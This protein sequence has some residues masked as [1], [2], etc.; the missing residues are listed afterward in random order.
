LPIIIWHLGFLGTG[1]YLFVKGPGNGEVIFSVFES[2]I[3]ASSQ[4]STFSP[5]PNQRFINSPHHD[6]ACV[7]TLAAKSVA[8]GSPRT[9]P[10]NRNVSDF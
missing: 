10:P 7:D 1:T 3:L 6:E 4:G 8:R 5:N 2:R 9:P